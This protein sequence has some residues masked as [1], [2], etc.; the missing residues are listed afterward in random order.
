MNDFFRSRAAELNRPL[1][2]MGAAYYYRVKIRN[3][4]EGVARDISNLVPRRPGVPVK[5][6]LQELAACPVVK[7]AV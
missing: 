2:E 4:T 3:I 5:S 1:S 6:T 7:A